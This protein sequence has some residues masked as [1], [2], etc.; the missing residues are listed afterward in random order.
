[1]PRRKKTVI[2]LEDEPEKETQI[3]NAESDIENALKSVPGGVTS[4]KLYRVLPQGGRPKFLTEL[5]PEEFSETN[6][7]EMYGGG[8]Y[9]IRVQ[10]SNGKWGVSMFDIEG[11]P[12]KLKPSDIE[13]DPD[14]EEE[15]THN[16]QPQ[17][18]VQQS[19]SFDAFAMMK[20]MQ[21]AEDRGEARMM[22]MLELMRPQQQP[23]D[24][25]KQVF[26]IV[27]KIAPMMA[28]GD[29]GGSPWMMALTQFK[30]PILKIVDSI[31]I[32]LQRPSVVPS[33]PPPQV[34][35][36]VQPNPTQPPSEDDMLK[37]LIRQYLPVFVNAARSNGNPDIYADMILEQIPE[38]MYPRLQQWLAGSWFQDIVAIE[39]NIEFQ[40][41][42]WNL[43]KTSLLEGMKEHAASNVQSSSDSEHSED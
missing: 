7:K 37:L 38:T 10:K 8:S 19:S 32:A 4:V 6:V 34:Y 14:E 23:P 11:F 20:M 25:T 5:S 42:W 18:A 3:E 40:A 17:Q 30:E 27:E 39:K 35:A 41:G 36:H 15:E 26:E 16:P 28:G 12:K 29:G 31:Q 33:G 2:E 22:K 9:K 13:E 43:L 24:V 1:M 21:A